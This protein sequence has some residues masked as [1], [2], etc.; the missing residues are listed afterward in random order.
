M[1]VDLEPQSTE[2]V[3][4]GVQVAICPAELLARRLRAGWPHALPQAPDSSCEIREFQQMLL[5]IERQLHP[6]HVPASMRTNQ[7]EIVGLML[8]DV[9]RFCLEQIQ[10]LGQVHLGG[11]SPN[12]QPLRSSSCT[13]GY[14]EM[15]FFL[16]GRALAPPATAAARLPRKP[17]RT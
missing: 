5:I 9:L 17:A 3:A 6:G 4:D 11:L 15:V 14:S 2:R 1:V 16:T 12:A 8:W 7:A 13:C 10:N